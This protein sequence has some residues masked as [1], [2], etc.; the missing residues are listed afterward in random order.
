MPY[1][2]AYA[3]TYASPAS[4]DAP[5][6]EVGWGRLVSDDGCSWSP[7]TALDDANTNRRAPA[8]RAASRRPTVCVTFASKVVIGSAIESGIP[9]RAARCTTAS[10]PVSAVRTRPASRS[11][12]RTRSWVTPRRYAEDPIERSSRTR[13]VQPPATRMRARFEPT[14]PAPPVMTASGAS[15]RATDPV[16]SALDGNADD[17]R[18][19]RDPADVLHE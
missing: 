3:S 15:G 4:F 11:E 18:G 17:R 1:A 16:A 13:T 19:L 6:G 12:P 9:A 2:A 8:A 5:Y 14:N 7:I 10:A